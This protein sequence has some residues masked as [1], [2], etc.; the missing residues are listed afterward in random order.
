MTPAEISDLLD[1]HDKRRPV[2]APLP[3]K[4]GKPIGTWLGIAGGVASVLIV[5]WQFG[6]GLFTTDAEAAVETAA[7]I[8]AEAEIEKAHGDDMRDVTTITGSQETGLELL[9]QQV[10]TDKVNANEARGRLE[11]RLD[12]HERRGH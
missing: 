10:I 8:A 1:A 9:K 7:R 6:D 5:F 4:V 12:R 11:K 3:K 2:T